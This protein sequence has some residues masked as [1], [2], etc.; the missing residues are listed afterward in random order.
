MMKIA[1]IIAIAALC[2]GCTSHPPVTTRSSKAIQL[3]ELVAHGRFD[4]AKLLAGQMTV[5]EMEEY[6]VIKL[7]EAEFKSNH[8]GRVADEMLAEYQ[9]FMTFYQAWMN[10]AERQKQ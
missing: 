5:S 6:W 4:D 10:Y 1:R 7:T 3:R 9:E 2:V 8:S